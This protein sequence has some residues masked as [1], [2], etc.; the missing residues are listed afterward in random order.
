MFAF[1]KKNI[2]IIILS[3]SLTVVFGCWHSSQSQQ[4]DTS[5]NTIFHAPS[6]VFPIDCN[7]GEDCFIMHYVDNDVSPEAADF[8]CGRQTYDGHQGTDF[9]IS[10]LEVMKTNMPVIAA[11]EGKVLRIRDG[12]VDRLVEEQTEKNRVAGQECGNGVVIDSG[13]G[14]ETQ[15]CHLKQGSVVV[16]PGTEVKQG[17][18]LGMVGASGLASF[19]HVHLTIRYQGQV[20]DPFS[21]ELITDGGCQLEDRSLWKESLSYVPTGLIRAG[22]SPKPPTQPELWQGQYKATELVLNSP[23]LVFWVHSYGV[24]QGDVEKWQLTAPDGTKAIASEN[25]VDKSY[26]SWVSYV[27]KRQLMPGTWQ[28]KYELIRQDSSIF[29]VERSVVVK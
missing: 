25:I 22:F 6:F 2:L 28:G 12:I 20:V 27:G 4:Q 16:K 5:T 9:G 18:V 13:N 26:R 1:R 17:T 8:N 29:T 7:L 10:D 11:T 24:L 23:A 3:L 19:P 21:G 15:Y 14:W